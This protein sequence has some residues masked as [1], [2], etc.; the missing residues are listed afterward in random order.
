MQSIERRN[1][2]MANCIVYTGNSAGLS[3]RASKSTSS[4]KLGV[5]SNGVTV[6]V[7][8]C[9]ATW[10]TFMY[11]STPAF[12]Q[13]QYLQDPPSTN[14]DGLSTGA[15]AT[16]NTNNVIIRDA[17]NGSSTGSQLSKG[18]GVTIYAKTLTSSYYW[19]RI[20]TNQWVRGDFLAP[21]G[22]GGT[23]SLQ[24]GHYVQV[25][26]G[27][28]N[29]RASASTSSTCLGVLR[30]D[31]K[32]Y[33]EE[34]VSSTWVKIRWGGK[35]QTYA[36]IMSQYLEDGGVAP[37]SKMQRAFDIGLS[38]ADKGYPDTPEECFDIGDGAWC[39]RYVSFLQKAAGCSAGNYVPFSKA[40]VSEAVAFFQTNNA[41]GLRGV[42]TPVEGD[43][44]FFRT[45]SQPY[46]HVGLVVYAN[47]TNI[48]TVEGN[49]N[50][51]VHSSGPSSYNGSF[52]DM[53]V[54][55]FGTPTWA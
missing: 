51:T 31:T 27:T 10:A 14:G 34:V 26:A 50:D 25:S 40:L 21:G 55:G 16:C 13:H 20:G 36:Y 3:V 33:C 23:G 53:T 24:A 7:V 5:I 9:D 37:T 42:K 54:Y 18:D 15:T 1:M 35:T 41:F 52:G 12:V 29:V 48:K 39:V 47:G 30:N 44:V 45:T 8:R 2:E 4:T 32:M 22:S 46:Q 28:V 49:R 19:Y 38:M 43:W 11:N 17:A 6:D